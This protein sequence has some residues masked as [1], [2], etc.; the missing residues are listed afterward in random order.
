MRTFLVLLFWCRVEP[1]TPNG[2][3]YLIQSDSVQS[4][5]IQALEECEGHYGYCKI[6]GCGT[7]DKDFFTENCHLI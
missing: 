2:D 5:C 4:A 3:D 7:N 6:L 1:I